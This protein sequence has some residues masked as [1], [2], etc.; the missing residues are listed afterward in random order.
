V[1]VSNGYSA[2]DNLRLDDVRVMGT[3]TFVSS[4]WVNGG[5][6]S[7]WTQDLITRVSTSQYITDGL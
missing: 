2:V 7:T 5:E 1:I 6:I 3:K 4:V